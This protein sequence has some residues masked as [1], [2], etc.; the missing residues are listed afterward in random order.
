MIPDETVQLELE[1]GIFAEVHP[2]GGALSRHHF[3]RQ[4]HPQ[5]A[6]GRR[7]RAVG[8]VPVENNRPAEE[9]KHRGDDLVDVIVFV[10]PPLPEHR[11][12]WCCDVTVNL[13]GRWFCE[14]GDN[15]RV[16]E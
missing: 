5:P 6:V 8:K 9:G 4:R 12:S 13:R 14:C 7:R 1:L 3:H 11:F 2:H 15:K 16:D 10:Q